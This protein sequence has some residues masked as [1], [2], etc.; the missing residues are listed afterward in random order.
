MQARITLATRVRLDEASRSVHIRGTALARSTYWLSGAL[1]L[2]TALAAAATLF[3][4]GVLRG[5]AVMNGA[6]W[7]DSPVFLLPPSQPHRL[8]SHKEAIYERSRV[9]RTRK[10]E[11]G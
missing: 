2:V 9:S 7:P 11:L 6:G 8:I 4:P 1:A 5:P 10:K 3:I